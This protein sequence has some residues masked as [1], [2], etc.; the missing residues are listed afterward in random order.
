MKNRVER[1]T[2]GMVLEECGS[3]TEGGDMRSGLGQVQT[4]NQKG[5]IIMVS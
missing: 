2:L 1:D 4:E 5:F 3:G